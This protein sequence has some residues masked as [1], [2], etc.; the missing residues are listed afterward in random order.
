MTMEV[1]FADEAYDATAEIYVIGAALVDPAVTAALAASMEAEGKQTSRPDKRPFHWRD[2]TVGRK[3]GFVAVTVISH[4][5]P[6]Y[7]V[8]KE[9]VTPGQQEAAR[10]ACLGRLVTEIVARGVNEIVLDKRNTDGKVYVDNR[11]M[12]RLRNAGVM[13][14]GMVYRFEYPANEPSLRVADA[15]SGFTMA[16]VAL[17]DTQFW[18]PVNTLKVCL[19]S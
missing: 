12:S 11:T 3:T 16:A 13:P 5:L 10:E 4:K 19:V 7:A 17:L 14:A 8:V 18:Q 1:A 15:V 6:V 2:A 9:R